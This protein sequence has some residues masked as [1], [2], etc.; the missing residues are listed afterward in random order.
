MTNHETIKMLEKR[1]NVHITRDFFYDPLS[2]KEYEDFKIYTAD[3]CCWDKVIGYR[4]LVHT[5]ASDKE[6]L[7]HIFLKTDIKH[8]IDENYE[9]DWEEAL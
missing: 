4:S 7:K 2:R 3:G 6:S 1:Y 8:Y 9:E 5:L